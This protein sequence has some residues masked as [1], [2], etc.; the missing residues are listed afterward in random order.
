[1][2]DRLDVCLQ[3]GRACEHW[4]PPL[5]IVEVTSGVKECEHRPGNTLQAIL[6]GWVRFA[7]LNDQVTRCSYVSVF[8]T[9]SKV[10]PDLA[11]VA[12]VGVDRVHLYYAGLWVG[13]DLPIALET[14]AQLTVPDVVWC[15]EDRI[16]VDIEY[17]FFLFD[18]IQ[19]LILSIFRRSL[20]F[21]NIKL[22]CVK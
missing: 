5:S 20:V 6:N 21:F 17:A 14:E 2:G 7:Y 22:Y 12:Q 9:C 18:L 3:L 10:D 13:E 11:R 1:M 19:A 8:V 4:S 15:L 16:K